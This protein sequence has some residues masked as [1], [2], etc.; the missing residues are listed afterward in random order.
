MEPVTD[1]C[2]V[3][4]SFPCRV[5]F[6]IHCR[7]VFRFLT[8]RDPLLITNGGVGVSR[9]C[10]LKRSRVASSLV[11]STCHGVSSLESVV[12]SCLV[13]VGSH[14]SQLKRPS[15]NEASS[16]QPLSTETL[17]RRRSFLSQSRSHSKA[18]T[19]GSLSSG[20]IASE[21]VIWNC[22]RSS[23]A[24]FACCLAHDKSSPRAV[25]CSRSRLGDVKESPGIF[26]SWN[27]SAPRLRRWSWTANDRPPLAK[28]LK[29][30]SGRAEL[31][32]LTDNSR[33][34]RDSNSNHC[35]GHSTTAPLRESSANLR[36]GKAS[37]ASTSSRSQRWSFPPSIRTWKGLQ[38]SC[39]C[40]A[41]FMRPELICQGSWS[42]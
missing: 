18:T 10:Q 36:S 16:I 9:S 23:F 19:L 34:F 5:K 40:T 22:C 8:S 38:L 2:P 26:K 7:S 35:F 3:S 37:C 42:R 32:G 14:R 39:N 15:G 24:N 21:G 4:S 13:A 33:R 17:S 12:P 28:P 29:V 1:P 11:S 20:W 31:A 41:V 6:S 27:W 25:N 30:R